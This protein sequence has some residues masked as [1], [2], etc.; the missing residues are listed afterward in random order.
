MEL[1]NYKTT[2][3]LRE[4]ERD[5]ISID[6]SVKPS[7]GDVGR[8]VHIS[9]DDVEASDLLVDEEF[10]IAAPSAAV[11]FKRT[12]EYCQWSETS[13]EHKRD[14]GTKYHTYVYTKG[15]RSYPIVSLFFDQPFAHHNPQEQP[16]P[17][18]SS[19]SSGARIGAFYAPGELM[20]D[21]RASFSTLEFK[22]NALANF[23]GSVAQ[24]LGFNYIGKGRFYRSHEASVSESLLRLT[25]RV[26]EGSLDLQIGELL[27]VCTAG[28]I[29][30]SFEVMAPSSVS[31]LARL[32]DEAGTLGTYS[33]TAGYD[34]A[35]MHAGQFT[36]E[37][38]IAT[39]KSDLR[40]AVVMVRLLLIPWCYV[41]LV[42][43]VPQVSNGSGAVQFAATA[44]MSGA[45]VSMW[46]C[47]FWGFQLASVLTLVGAL[48]GLVFAVTSATEGKIRS[49]TA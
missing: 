41:L 27:S 26:F 23:E 7:L 2:M 29:R 13:V 30:V 25:G 42:S 39:A 5:A 19:Q 33:T 22:R 18:R 44:C 47:V 46:W 36:I 11:K 10:G 17:D 6:S 8:L 45:I 28:D 37:E 43:L 32:V 48:G 14:D 12:V 34:L 40:W 49:K 16:L 24:R 1:S 15:W 9:S 38:M 3:A 21:L 35:L 20:R 4:A 31:V